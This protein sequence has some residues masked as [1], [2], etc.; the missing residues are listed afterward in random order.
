MKLSLT[1]SIGLFSTGAQDYSASGSANSKAKKANSS[2]KRSG[3]KNRMKGVTTTTAMP[4]HEREEKVI[5]GICHVITKARCDI[6]PY[7][8]GWF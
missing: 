4:T 3:K 7:C 6:A 1:R 5:E 8:S 2:K